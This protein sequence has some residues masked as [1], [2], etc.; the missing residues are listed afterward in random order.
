MVT[1]LKIE[2]KAVNLD[3]IY[4]NV[5]TFQVVKMRQRM[6]MNEL[7]EWFLHANLKSNI[8]DSMNL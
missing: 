5:M 6:F 7:F 2:N 3:Y 4:I 8:D 1:M